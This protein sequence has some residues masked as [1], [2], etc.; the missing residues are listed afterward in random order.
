MRTI[1]ILF[2][3][4]WPEWIPESNPLIEILRRHFIVELSQEPDFVIYSNFGYRH[5]AYDVPRLFYTGE[6]LSPD[7]NICDYG[8]G[9]YRLTF[10]DRYFR[11]TN[12]MMDCHKELCEVGE[13]K[14]VPG[15]RKFCNFVYSNPHA[16]P[17]RDV[18]F[19]MLSQYKH[20]DSAG[21]HLNNTDF[22]IV[23]KASLQKNYKFS[24]A[25]E[26]S[27]SPGYTS[28]KLIQAY[29][30]GTVPIYW[31]DRDVGLDF[32]PEAFVNC[33]DFPSFEKAIE[34]VIQLDN[35]E[36][37][38]ARMFEASF[39]RRPLVGYAFEPGFED[40]L[41][42]IFSQDKEKAFRRNRQFWG[43]AYETQRRKLASYL[44]RMER[45]PFFK[46]TEHLRMLG[47]S[48]T[49]KKINEKAVERKQE[50]IEAKLRDV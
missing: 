40:F 44:T 43:K 26:N 37:A 34:R 23:D 13:R 1:K 11:F 38:Y 5:L 14:Y 35:D 33:H 47:T 28:E 25:F 32:N 2:T 9:Y 46:L 29:A 48:G 41:V 20:V 17:T 4:F 12:Y 6:N 3:D 19:R 24:I 15:P 39:F 16:D 31:G 10:G 18:F 50:R 45:R 30:A 22:R 42:H 49:V 27:S 36:E 21:R 8:L 7:F